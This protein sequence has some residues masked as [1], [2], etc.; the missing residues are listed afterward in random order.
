MNDEYCKRLEEVMEICSK[1]L[2]K[3][4]ADICGIILAQYLSDCRGD[5]N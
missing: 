3:K 1:S 2:N 5:S 4:N